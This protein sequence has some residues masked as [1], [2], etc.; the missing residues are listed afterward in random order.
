MEIIAR[1]AVERRVNIMFALSY[2]GAVSSIGYNVFW[3]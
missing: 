1:D 3:D 2:N